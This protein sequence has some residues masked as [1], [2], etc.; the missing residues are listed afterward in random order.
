MNKLDIDKLRFDVLMLKSR[1]TIRSELGVTYFQF[2]S[3]LHDNNIRYSCNE[4]RIYVL[5]QLHKGVHYNAIP[6]D[7]DVMIKLILGYNGKLDDL[8]QLE[9]VRYMFSL[10]YNHLEISNIFKINIRKVKSIIKK[11]IL[12]QR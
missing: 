5:Q 4:S 2:I 7:K 10:G 3:I 11:Y 12:W 1:H 9:R 6:M 8:P